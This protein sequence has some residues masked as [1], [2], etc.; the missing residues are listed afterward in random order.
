M[1]EMLILLIDSY[2]E[3]WSNRRKIV[4]VEYFNE[5]DLFVDNEVDTL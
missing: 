5:L 2:R 1:I 3:I 4:V